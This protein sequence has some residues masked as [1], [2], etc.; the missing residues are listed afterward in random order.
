MTNFVTIQFSTYSSPMKNILLQLLY[1]LAYFLTYFCC[2]SYKLQAQNTPTY[3]I[4]HYTDSIFITKIHI[5]CNHKT[6]DKIIFREL[7]IREGHRVYRKSLDSLLERESYKLMNTKLFI[8]AEVVPYHFKGDSIELIVSVI[9]KW[10]LYPIP[11]IDFADRSFNEWAS[12]GYNIDRL[13]YGMRLV[14][15]NFRGRNET[16]K[17]YLQLGFVRVAEFE[18]KIPYINKKQTTGLNFRVAYT[19]SK[20]SFYV[21]DGLRIN[22][23]SEKVLEEKLVTSIGITK[24]SKFYSIHKFNLSYITGKIT[25]SLAILSPT[26][27][28]NAR[29]RQQFFQLNYV[30]EKDIRDNISFPL[31][32]NFLQVE[33]YQ[34]GLTQLDDIHTFQAQFVYAKFIPISKKFFYSVSWR[35]MISLPQQQ[36][37]SEMRGYGFN[38][39]F[40]RGMELNQVP[41][42]HFAVWKNTFRWKMFHKVFN[43]KKIF[44]VDQFSTFPLAIYPKIYADGGY[45][46]SNYDYGANLFSNQ[47]LWGLGAGLDFVFY[48]STVIRF[49]YSPNKYN[50]TQFFVNIQT[51]F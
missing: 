6:I 16:L 29:T 4:P 42:Q 30:F 20:N 49:E 47:P 18:Y 17:F 32:G 37:L 24:R 23:T 31:K 40:I 36:P 3:T 38:G 33:V 21:K 1:F 8:L 28:T 11:I 19:N 51:D 34:R 7:A 44:N 22:Y 15:N 14:Q 2:I 10:Y 48:N 12:K 26:Y 13:I 46:Y 50:A 9:E 43:L 35:G 27:Y 41:G 5:D 25:D 39:N 45:V